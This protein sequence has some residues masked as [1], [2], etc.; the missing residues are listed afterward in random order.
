MVGRNQEILVCKLKKSI[1]VLRTA[2]RRWQHKLRNVLD[3]MGFI[4]LKF[5]TNVF[6]KDET[7]V[8]TYVDDFMINSASNTKIKQAITALSQAF[9][10]KDLGDM[11]KFL[12]IN[13]SQQP[14]GI[15]IDQ[16]DKIEDLCNN[17]GMLF[18]RSSNTPVANDNLIDCDTEILCTKSDAVK[19]RSAVGSLLYIARMTRPDIQ[20]AIDRLSRQVQKFSQNSMLALKHLVRYILRTISVALFFPA[21]GNDKLTREILFLQKEQQVFFS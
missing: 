10:V 20:Y 1:Y 15:R 5:D 13:I 21:N 18:C 3:G 14:D 9:Q 8:S 12:G 16:S 17:M 4:P 6:R 11:T 2:P 7:I 19:Y